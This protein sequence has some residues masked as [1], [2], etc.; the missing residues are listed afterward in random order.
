[1]ALLPSQAEVAREEWTWRPDLEDEGAR[2]IVKR[3]P[4]VSTSNQ[5][6]ILGCSGSESFFHGSTFK[7]DKTSEGSSYKPTI[8]GSDVT[9]DV[10][11]QSSSTPGHALRGRH[12]THPFSASAFLVPAFN[13]C[14][15][16]SNTSNVSPT[17][18]DDSLLRYTRPR[19]GRNSLDDMTFLRQLMHL[20]ISQGSSSSDSSL[21]PALMPWTSP[22]RSPPVFCT[23]AKGAVI[24]DGVLVINDD[25]PADVRSYYSAPRRL[26]APC[27]A[28]SHHHHFRRALARRSFDDAT[29][30]LEHQMMASAFQMKPRRRHRELAPPSPP[31]SSFLAPSGGLSPDDLQWL[32]PEASVEQFL[33]G[34]RRWRRLPVFELICPEE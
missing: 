4:S 12:A 27:S 26:A 17:D 21:S 33:H 28:A 19:T 5:S 10:Q 1:M 16:D 23:P 11:I 24:E 31:A 8:Y 9:D 6:A 25:P 15:A 32:D 3:L 20:R 34:P 2:R 22:A 7:D 30:H 18:V 29:H 13:A 14:A